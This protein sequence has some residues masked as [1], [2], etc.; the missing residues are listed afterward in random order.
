MAIAGEKLGQFGNWVGEVAE[1]VTGASGVISAQEEAAQ[2][3][4]RQAGLATQQAQTQATGLQTALGTAQGQQQAGFEA[5]QQGLQPYLQQGQQYNQQLQDMLGG[6]PTQFTSPEPQNRGQI[7]NLINQG[8]DPSSPEIMN[9]INQGQSQLGGDILSRVQQ[10]MPV[11]QELQDLIGSG[12]NIGPLEESRGYQSMLQAR[13]EGLRDLSTQMGGLG[14]F[15]SGST[16]AAAGDISGRLAQQLEQQ[17]YGRAVG[18][19]G[20]DIAN[21]FA[22]DRET[23]GRGQNQLAQLMGIEQQQYGRGQTQLGQLQGIEQ[24]QY[25]RGQNL[26]QQLAALESTDYGRKIQQ[27]QLQYGSE[28]DYLSRLTGQAGQGQ[29]LAQ[30]LAQMQL[31]QG[32]LAGGQTMATQGNIANIMTGGQAQASNLLNLMGQQNVGAAQTA[33]DSR[34]D[35]IGA[36]G[37]VAG[38]AIGKQG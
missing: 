26:A 16:A 6:G 12:L 31:G 20:Q 3:S 24:Q 29:A 1:D 33:A 36:I 7:M 35:L 30:M 37:T 11:S 32:N 13:G 28:Q 25:G 5:A 4:R 8:M 2:E 23:Y 9:L 21:R 15:F 14:K 22:L 18:E 17:Q 34:G 19:R 10:G 38:A 27:Q